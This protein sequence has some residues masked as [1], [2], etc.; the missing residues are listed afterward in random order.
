MGQFAED[1]L[2]AE[3]GDAYEKYG[4]AR[5]KTSTFEEYDFYARYKSFLRSEPIVSFTGPDGRLMALKPD[6]TLS[7]AKNA[8][9]AP[10]AALKAY[11]RE[12][13]Y[14]QGRKTGELRE[15]TQAG[16]ELIG[17]IDRYALCE[18][19][20]MAVLSLRAIGG[21][22]E[23]AVSHMGFVEALLAD[24]GLSGEDAN[25]ALAMIGRRSA[26]ELRS[27]IADE[28]AA[29]RLLALIDCY[30]PLKERL[31]ALEALD[32]NAATHA[33]LEEL[34]NL[35]DDLAAFGAGEN[36]SVDFSIINDMDYYGGVI[37]KGYA[38]GI[39]HC[40]LSGGRYDRLIEKLGKKGG[41]VG[42]AVYPDVLEARLQ[43][44]AEYDADTLLLYDETTS[45]QDIARAVEMFGKGGQRVLVQRDEPAVGR[46]RSKVRMS[47]RGFEMQC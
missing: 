4:Y 13:V 15:I 6:V 9:A 28:A 11:Y 1:R 16:L 34:K 21:E 36:L 19:T 33:A 14:R 30:G 26:H 2:L 24:A 31:P 20:L 46:Y 10:T 7:I 38:D 29:S 45:A 40:V 47:G 22:T 37:F 25:R 42:F 5:Y 27:L 12:S 8:P 39:A 32:I 44:G 35:W 41:A 3:L 18:V 23:L 17:V 43:T